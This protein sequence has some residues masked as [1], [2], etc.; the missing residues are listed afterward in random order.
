MAFYVWQKQYENVMYKILLMNEFLTDPRELRTLKE[1]GHGAFGKVILMQ[2][3]KKESKVYAVKTEDINATIPQLHYEFRV[4]KKLHGI[5]GIPAVHAL[6]QHNGH[7]HMAMQLLGPS[8]EKVIQSITLWDIV[9]WVAPKTLSIL[10]QIHARGFLHRDIKPENM[11]LG[12]TGLRGRDI[13]LVDYGLSKR[14]RMDALDH[15]PYKDGKRL[16]GTVRYASVH[17]H[18]GEEQSRRDDLESLG[19]VLVYLIKHKLPWMNAGGNDKREQGE[20]IMNI[21]VK[22]SM[23]DLCTGL[24][25]A[26]VHYFRHV[27][28][29]AYDQTPDYAMLRAFFKQ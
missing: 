6:W 16:T 8:L 28:A 2:D 19:Y 21:K 20:R 24:P 9:T 15:I 12:V 25:L 26:F 18:L 5:A 10:E 17:T 27:R 7:T 3:P 11:L 29:L 4:Y 13:Y 1:I 14:Y 23:E 22:T